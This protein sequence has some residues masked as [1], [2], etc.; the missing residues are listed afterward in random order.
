MGDIKKLKFNGV[1]KE[2]KPDPR[3]YSISRFVPQQD[4]IKEEEFCM[5]LPKREIIIDQTVYNSCVGHSFAICKSILEYQQTKKWIDFDP[6]IIYGTR[7]PIDNYNGEGM[8]PRQGAKVLEKEGAFL[9]RDFNRKAEMPAIKKIVEDFKTHNPELVKTA[10]NYKIDGYAFIYNTTQLK[11]AL[12]SGMPVSAAWP[13]YESFYGVKD[14]GI[15]V[16]PNY[17]RE[18]LIGYHQM[19]VVGWTSEDYWIVLNSWGIDYGMKGVYFIP[20]NYDFDSAIAV[21]DTI[22]P[23]QTKAS[24]IILKINSNYIIINGEKQDLD[25]SPRIYKSRTY[26]PIRKV[27]EALGASVEWINSEK[28]VIIRSEEAEIVMEINNTDFLI[29]GETYVNDVAPIIVENRTLLPIRAIAEAL[30]CEVE[31]EDSTKTIL[32][33]AL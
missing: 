24:E 9:R 21:T 7:Y 3:D 5:K 31:W 4:E 11:R 33:K 22:S 30:N 14:D 10:K 13:L 28:K 8:Y 15:V 19:T 1:L 29:N 6:Y 25:V 18:E 26:V 17:D 12:K 27:V 23:S 16:K 2:E 20:F 32:I